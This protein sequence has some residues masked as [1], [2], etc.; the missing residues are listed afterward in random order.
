M[1][2]IPGFE[3]TFHSTNVFVCLVVGFY[4]GL[5]D[6][7]FLSAPSAEGTFMF[8][9]AVAILVCV[10]RLRCRCEGFGVVGRDYLCHI[11]GATVADFDIVSIQDFVES[12]LLGKVFVN[13][14]QKQFVDVCGN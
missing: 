8:F 5:V 11:F 9:S 1:V 3:A 7:G 2:V 4:C 14:L 6:E 12:V 10:C 13:E